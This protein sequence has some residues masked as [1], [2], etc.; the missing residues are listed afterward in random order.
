MND[1]ATRLMARMR[2]TVL[3][4]TEDT[5]GLQAMLESDQE[6]TGR[7]ACELALMHLN[8]IREGFGRVDAMLDELRTITDID[9]DE[10]KVMK[11]VV[12]AMRTDAMNFIDSVLDLY[13]VALKAEDKKN[14]ETADDS[15]SRGGA[16]RRPRRRSKA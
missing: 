4:L 9:E 13:S 11:G 2:K 8:D 1:K 14:E 3:D 10:V 16:A 7:E 5:D 6:M 15:A 12:G